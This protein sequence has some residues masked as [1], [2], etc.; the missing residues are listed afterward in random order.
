MRDRPRTRP[1]VC[2]PPPARRE[3]RGTAQSAA[4][5]LSMG[6]G[7]QSAALAFRSA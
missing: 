1:P 4:V 6:F 7:G 5:G 2:L 3:P